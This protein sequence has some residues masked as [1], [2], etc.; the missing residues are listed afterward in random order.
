MCS[1][2]APPR[3]DTEQRRLTSSPPLLPGGSWSADTFGWVMKNSGSPHSSALQH[4][5]CAASSAIALFVLGSHLC[6]RFCMEV[7]GQEGE[8]LSLRCW[9]AR[10]YEGYN[11]YWCRGAARGSCHKVVETAG[12][13]VPRQ[14]G[15][16]SITDNH[17]FCVV[18]LTVEELSMEDAGSYWC[19][20]ERAGRDIMEPVTV[21]VRP[22]ECWRR[23][24][25]GLCRAERFWEAAG[26][27]REGTAMR[28]TAPQPCCSYISWHPV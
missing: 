13:E 9:Y 8:T 7:S 15:R 6:W 1:R 12:R 10:G 28:E 25:S 23:V 11:K 26:S 17:I 14:H 24:G 22:G 18:L 5:S 27:C 2:C 16:V 19:G 21:R 4:F 20:V 3:A